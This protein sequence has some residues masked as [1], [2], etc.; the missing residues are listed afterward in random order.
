MAFL[1]GTCDVV[2]KLSNIIRHR[3]VLSP[4]ATRAVQAH[5]EN[6][7]ALRPDHFRQKTAEEAL[8]YKVL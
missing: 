7:P 2:D 5:G 8:Q 3:K 6:V 1:L 4:N